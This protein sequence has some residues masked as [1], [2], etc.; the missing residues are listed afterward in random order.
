[1]GA[2][3]IAVFAYN[4]PAHIARALRALARCP[5]LAASPVTIYCD[6]PKSPDGRAK[7][8]ATRK[9]VREVA[10]PHAKIVER[11]ENL[12]LARSIRTGV[13]ELCAEHGR[14]IVLEDDLEV[15][16]TFLA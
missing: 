16:A 2:A 9:T 3:P 5:E 15:S 1:M 11:D 12:G 13:G 14:A 4:R 8:E 6:G 10:P 7:T